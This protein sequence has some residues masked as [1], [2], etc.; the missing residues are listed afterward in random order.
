[1]NY[2]LDDLLE[3][4]RQKDVFSIKDV[5]FAVLESSGKLSI[6]LKPDKQPVTR[7]DMQITSPP[8][9]LQTELIMDGQIVLQNLAQKNLSEDW[10]VDELARQGIF[11]LS[12]VNYAGIDSDQTLYID[13]RKD[14]N[15]NPFNITD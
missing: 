14:T 6:Q 7:Q 4:L 2:S 3:E 10:L 13:I 1:M 15:I 12:Q 5:Q 11:D 9:T 8:Q